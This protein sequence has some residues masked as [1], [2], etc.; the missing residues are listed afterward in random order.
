MFHCSFAIPFPSLEKNLCTSFQVVKKTAAH[1]KY[2]G[3]VGKHWVCMQRTLSCLL[4]RVGYS[5]T[6]CMLPLL[7]SI[8]GRLLTF[9]LSLHPNADDQGFLHSQGKP[10]VYCVRLCAASVVAVESMY[11]MVKPSM[12]TFEY[13]ASVLLVP[14]PKDRGLRCIIPFL[15]VK[16]M[17]TIKHAK[18]PLRFLGGSWRTL[19]MY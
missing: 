9:D 19:Y 13:H 12:I 3:D 5:P 16:E 14:R 11:G 7:E 18:P 10:A 1:V 15:V 8:S 6:H 2:L 4:E 17:S